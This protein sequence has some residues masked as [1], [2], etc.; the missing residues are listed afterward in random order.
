MANKAPLP[1]PTLT[2]PAAAPV[3][4]P[5]DF[6]EPPAQAPA[7]RASKASG[8]PTFSS[9]GGGGD[10]GETMDV[11]PTPR[12]SR[13]EAMAIDVPGYVP[14]PFG[15]KSGPTP[16]AGEDLV[17]RGGGAEV[18][19]EDR[20]AKLVEKMR[21]DKTVAKILKDEREKRHGFNDKSSDAVDGADGAAPAAAASAETPAADDKPARAETDVAEIARQQRENREL[22]QRIKLAEG[23]RAEAKRVEEWKKIAKDYPIA[24]MR[25]V[26]GLEPEAI[27]EDDVQGKSKGAG[28]KIP[29]VDPA[30]A[31]ADEDKSAGVT[32]ELE[33]ERARAVRAE[34]QLAM[35]R[36]TRSA[37]SVAKEDAKRWELCQRD[38]DIGRTVVS[39]VQRLFR[40]A[41]EKAGGAGKGW[42]PIDD[43][44]ARELTASVL[45]D[46]EKHFDSLGKRYAKGAPSAAP[47]RKP[48][49]PRGQGGQFQQTP[50]DP[51]NYRYTR[52]PKRESVEDRQD[53]LI[54]RYRG[55][56]LVDD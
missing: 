50:A 37:A 8:D 10:D 51:N 43:K 32:G 52:P 41:D 15:G 2:L 44:E 48:V 19:V 30:R 12:G 5:S 9:G 33:Q 34:S 39:E 47:S 55:V 45:D 11:N 6:A 27:Y 42:R 13:Q 31:I 38:P 3:L 54:S 49:P 29:K 7:V 26:L 23:S 20:Q 28:D 53:R 24:A 40:E 46:L 21:A 14:D 16:L 17:R 22:K 4:K 56:S 35:E 18:R 36:A 1:N 25:E